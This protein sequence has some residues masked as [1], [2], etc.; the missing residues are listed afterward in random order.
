M[1]AEPTTEKQSQDMQELIDSLESDV[2][3]WTPEPND[4]L[5]GRIVDIE[6]RASEYGKYPAITVESVTGEQQVFHA[7][8]TVALNE[9]LRLQPEVG[10]LIAVR[11]F[12]KD[13]SSDYHNYKV[14]I[15]GKQGRSF[16]W[17]KFE[18]KSKPGTD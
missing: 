8:R 1:A 10:D 9:V 15:Q 14:R 2:P 16:D 13:A 17:D 3:A 5:A 12:G 11:Y 4:I 7:Y 6:T 18:P